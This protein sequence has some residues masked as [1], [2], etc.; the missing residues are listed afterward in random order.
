MATNSPLATG[1][2]AMQQ[3]DGPSVTGRLAIHRNDIT[4]TRCEVYALIAGLVAGGNTGE[5]VC[6]NKSAIQ[7]FSKARNLANGAL[8]H[9]KYRDHHRIEIRTLC[10]H[11]QPSGTMTPLW[12]RSHQEHLQVDDTMLQQRRA[13]LATVDEAAGGAHDLQLPISYSDLITFDDYVVYDEDHRL[14]FG[15]VAQY[16]KKRAYV[17]LHRK[18]ISRQHCQDATKHTMAIDELDMA[19]SGQWLTSLCRFYWRARMSVLHTNAV[20]HR[21]D[22][23]WSAKCVNCSH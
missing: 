5:Q 14:V 15:N 6:D 13:A 7:I 3:P 10:R 16:V 18:W 22:H 2:W 4:S 19:A 8:C 1:T 11:M 23:R 12:I 17:D 9:I 21:F 20:K